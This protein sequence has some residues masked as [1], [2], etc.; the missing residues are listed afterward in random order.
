MH[1]SGD[2]DNGPFEWHVGGT[3]GV[4]IKYLTDVSIIK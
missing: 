2:A 4:V 3:F 1:A